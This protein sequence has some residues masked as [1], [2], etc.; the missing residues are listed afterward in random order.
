MSMQRPPAISIV[1]PFRDAAATLS[2]CLESIKGQTFADFE[3][4]AIDDGSADDSA[5]VVQQLAQHDGRVRLLRPGRVGL[6]A[7]LNLGIAQ[8]HA[9]LIARMDA[10]DLM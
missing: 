3:L 2:E 6:V 8:A 1:M 4:L 5:A 7:A 10:D 9:P